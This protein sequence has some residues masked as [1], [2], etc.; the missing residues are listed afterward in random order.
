MRLL[1]TVFMLVSRLPAFR[2]E[3]ARRTMA[4]MV[5]PFQK[6]VARA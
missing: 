4:E 5:K 6:A 3:Y 1:V 2:R